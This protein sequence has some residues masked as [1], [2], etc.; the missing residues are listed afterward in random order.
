MATAA[1]TNKVGLDATTSTWGAMATGDNGAPVSTNGRNLSV[2]V[3]GTFGGATV[4]MQG[5]NDGTNWATLNDQAVPGNV[6]SFTSAGFKGVLQM[7]KY[8][9]PVVSGG[10]G[11]G[12]IV[13]MFNTK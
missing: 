1:V 12:L 11:S 6:C 4:T 3:L 9:R 8:I 10:A 13:I 7:P 2:Q 5:S